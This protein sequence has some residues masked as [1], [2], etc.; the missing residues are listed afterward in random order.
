MSTKYLQES[1][2][3]TDQP[4]AGKPD[5]EWMFRHEVAL[6]QVRRLS[7]GSTLAEGAFSDGPGADQ[8]LLNIERLL[9]AV[10]AVPFK[11]ESGTDQVGRAKVIRT[12]LL[13]TAGGRALLMPPALQDETERAFCVIMGKLAE[14][15]SVP[16]AR[17]T[18]LFWLLTHPKQLEQFYVLTLRTSKTGMSADQ[19]VTAFVESFE[20]GQ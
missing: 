13:A 9:S 15:C 3:A 4:L 20:T 10:A 11:S 14:K 16:G 17:S 19:V 5:W 12:G 8:S 6:R 7:G 18:I 1:R 2:D